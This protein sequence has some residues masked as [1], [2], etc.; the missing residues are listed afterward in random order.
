MRHISVQVRHIKACL[1]KINLHWMWSLMMLVT[2]SRVMDIEFYL[3]IFSLFVFHINSVNDTVVLFYF[4][5]K[6]FFFLH[7]TT[8]TESNRIKS[9]EKKISSEMMD[10]VLLVLGKNCEFV[11]VCELWYLN[12]KQWFDVR[13]LIQ[14]KGSVVCWK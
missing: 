2:N 5:P 11:R 9:Q 12:F 3:F 13:W 1:M 8:L 4:P 7:W 10:Y 6:W 14:H